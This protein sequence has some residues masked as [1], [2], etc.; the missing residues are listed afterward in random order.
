MTIPHLEPEER[1][2]C[3]SRAFPDRPRLLYDANWVYGIWT[4]GA[5][6][7][8]HNE[9]WAPIPGWHY[10]AS[11]HGRIRNDRFPGREPLVASSPKDGRP[12]VELFDGKGKSK[13]IYVHRLVCS[14]FHGEPLN[15]DL[16][17]RHL[18][19]DPTNNAPYNLR[20]GTWK[21]NARDRDLHGNTVAWKSIIDR[22]TA[23]KARELYKKHMRSRQADGFQRAQRGFVKNLAKELGLSTSSTQKVLYGVT[24]NSPDRPRGSTLYGAYPH[25][26]LDRVH[27]MF[28]DVRE[29]LHVFSGGLR[30]VDVDIGWPP[31]FVRGV[32][33]EVTRNYELVDL[34]GPAEGRYPT[35]QGSLFDMPEDWHGRFDLILADPPYSEDDAKKYGTKNP[36]RGKTFRHLRKF[37]KTGGHLVWLDQQWPMHSKEQW[38]CWAHIGLVRSTQHRVRL[39]SMFEAVGVQDA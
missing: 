20:W 3:Y 23:Y 8:N 16:I 39:V 11:T 5:Y 7:K 25:G 1:A 2:V 32:E 19:G 13:R 10:S 24:W 38:K 22:N 9:E 36:P 35:W 4:I 37:A 30:V 28:P 14:A 33:Q 15:P 31:V 21:E 12:S 6:Y 27:S 17:V 34:K 29:I 18:D 26:Y